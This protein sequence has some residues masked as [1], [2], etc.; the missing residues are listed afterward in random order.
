MAAKAKCEADKFTKL[1]GYRLRGHTGNKRSV[2]MTSGRSL[3]TRFYRLRSGNVPIGMYLKQSGQQEVVKSWWF[4]SRTVQTR[5]HLCCHFRQFR[6]QQA[7]IWKTVVKATGCKVGRCRYVQIS[8]LFSMEKCNQVVM[9]LLA[10][11][12]VGRFLP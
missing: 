11:T 9:D 2:P 8:E 1:C 3:V 7:E 4:R 6:D 10:G 12:E 5:Q